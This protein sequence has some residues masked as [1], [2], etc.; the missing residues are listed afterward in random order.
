MSRLS[1]LGQNLLSNSSKDKTETS[2]RSIAKLDQNI[3]YSNETAVSTQESEK[4]LDSYHQ[5]NNYN[6]LLQ[7]Q[8]NVIL[9]NYYTKQQEL[10]Q[11]N[12]KFLYNQMKIKEKEYALINQKIDQ[13]KNLINDTFQKEIE[14]KKDLQKLEILNG[15]TYQNTQQNELIQFNGIHYDQLEQ[16]RLKRLDMQQKLQQLINQ[17]SVLEQQYDFQKQFAPIDREQ[18]QSFQDTNLSK[19]IKV[20]KSQQIKSFQKVELEIPPFYLKDLQ[21][22]SPN[23]KSIQ[24]PINMPN[25]HD[26][27]LMSQ[28]Y[29]QL[30]DLPPSI[31]QQFD[32]VPKFAISKFKNLDEFVEIMAKDRIKNRDLKKAFKEVYDFDPDIYIQNVKQAQYDQQKQEVLNLREELQRKQYLDQLKKNKNTDEQ[33]KQTVVQKSSLFKSQQNL[34]Q[35]QSDNDEEGKI[36]KK[37]KK[38]IIG[39]FRRVA[40]FFVIFKKTMQFYIHNKRDVQMKKVYN[41]IS[42]AL[43]DSKQYIKVSCERAFKLLVYDKKLNIDL[44]LEKKSAKEV[45]KSKIQQLKNIV[46]VMLDCL[47]DNLSESQISKELILFFAKLTKQ[48]SFPPP[49]YLTKFELERIQFTKYGQY[50]TQNKSVMQ[51]IIL[52]F[53]IVRILL[54][55]ILNKPWSVLEGVQENQQLKQQ[56]NKQINYFYHYLKSLHFICFFIKRNCYYVCAIIQQIVLQYLKSTTATY[57]ESQLHVLKEFQ[58][59]QRPGFMKAKVDAVISREDQQDFQKYGEPLILGFPSE[60]N[61]QVIFSDSQ[62][63][64]E[65]KETLQGFGDKLVEMVLKVQKNLPEYQFN[66]FQQMDEYLKSKEL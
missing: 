7:Y 31:Q 63:A 45:N 34:Q 24:K 57:N 38:Q 59:L 33:K 48:F 52:H 16:N 8:N 15:Y 42:Q 32:K 56:K 13:L 49:N 35:N 1:K 25:Y 43:N 40:F 10:E 19:K 9:Q 27:K 5:W 50:Q 23:I 54:Q 29:N 47:I 30:V 62:W 21:N 37:R 6:S 11:H 44:E 65:R 28:S 51:M 20:N 3:T 17:K 36:S 18:D 26:L 46:K 61:M 58:N 66:I 14:I 2:T 53:F 12:Q 4:F 39:Q 41:L 22:K 64:T 55:E 60:L